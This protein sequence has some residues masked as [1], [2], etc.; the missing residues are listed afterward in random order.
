MEKSRYSVFASLCIV[1][2]VLLIL[3]N[4][5]YIKG[6]YNL[7]PVFPLV[8]GIGLYLLYSD[9]GKKDA[10]VLGMGVYLIQF[11]ILAFY[12]NYTSW[13]SMVHLWPLFVGFLGV[14][15]LSVYISTGKGI[16]FFH[17]AVFLIGLC[18]VFFL[19]FSVDYRLWPISLVLFGISILLI[20]EFNKT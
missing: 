18:V 12:E 15:F 10:V 4:Y 11:S 9:R 19:I 17:L 13:S 1:I 6:V 8:L 3:E 5:G 20:K 7:W 2:G 14:S 16:I